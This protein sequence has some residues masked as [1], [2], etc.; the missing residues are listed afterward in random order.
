MYKI[1]KR[2]LSIFLVVLLAMVSTAALA[3]ED[4][5]VTGTVNESYQIVDDGGVV[6]DVA[7]S[8][9]GNEVVALIGKKVEVIGTVV[10]N[11]GTRE[12]TIASFK[13]IEE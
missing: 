1:T 11:D 9:K 6:Y 8:E 13:V 4:V 12:I 7:E 2:L 3:T 10:D 5:T